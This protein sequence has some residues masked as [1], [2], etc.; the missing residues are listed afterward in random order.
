MI[1][2]VSKQ[3]AI[4]DREERQQYSEKNWNAFAD[5][6]IFYSFSLWWTEFWMSYLYFQ[7]INR[8][9]TMQCKQWTTLS[10]R[11]T[12]HSISGPNAKFVHFE[13]FLQTNL[14]KCLVVSGYL[15]FLFYQ[16]LTELVHSLNIFG[17]NWSSFSLRVFFARPRRYKVWYAHIRADFFLWTI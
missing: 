3:A 16:L 5:K 9:V 17:N 4:W 15:F 8:M 11:L 10:F 2:K 13:S 7:N 14:Q 6:Y 1:Q 12:P